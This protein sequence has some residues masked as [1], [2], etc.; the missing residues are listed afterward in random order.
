MKREFINLDLS[1]DKTTSSI[2]RMMD[3]IGCKLRI[4]YTMKNNNSRCWLEPCRCLDYK[5]GRYYNQSDNK[6]K[7]LSKRINIISEKNYIDK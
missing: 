2:F 6:R 4:H 7:N 5:C 3:E 1:Y